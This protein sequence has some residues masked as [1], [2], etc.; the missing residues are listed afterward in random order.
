MPVKQMQK[1]T[2]P[3]QTNFIR[4]RDAGWSLEEEGHVLRR[5]RENTHILVH[6]KLHTEDENTPILALVQGTTSN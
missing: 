6:H 1:T 2:G 5:S 3:K 4:W